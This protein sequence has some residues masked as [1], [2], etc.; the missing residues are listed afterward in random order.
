ML[1]QIPFNKPFIAGKELYYIAQAVTLNNLA[2]DGHF[3]QQCC[4]LLEQTFGIHRVLLTPSCTAA[5]EM[6]AILCDL[7]PGD[8]VILPSFTFVSTASAFV[9]EGARPVFVDIRPDTLNIDENRIEEAVTD[10][11]RAIVPVHYAGIGCEMDRI[12]AIAR[13]HGLLVVE[14]A[15]QGVNSFYAGKAL[16]SI[17]D[18]GAYSF[19]ETKNYIAGE[20]GALCINRPDL[21]E[22]AE[23]I[24]DKGTNRQKFFRGLV[25]KYT[26]VDVGSSYVPSEI[27]GA[28]LYGQLEMMGP[29]SDRRREIYQFYRRH[30]KPLE[31]EGLLQL[32]YTPED[33]AANYHMFYVL[34]KDGPT[35]N[36][37]MDHL[38]QHG[39]G[40]VFH[41]V[42]L[43]SSPMGRRLGG[44][45]RELPVTDSASARL[46]R[47]PFYYTITE[48]E[49]AEVVRQIAAYFG[50]ATAKTGSE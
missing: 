45:T 13:K 4:R 29:I 14:D 35:R 17:G 43:H 42:P 6:A 50:C 24:R 41:Y 40:A 30:L 25:D 9:R 2:G 26:W 5:L 47:L 19:H 46:V 38:H 36:A 23:I 39:I 33:C 27:V 48:E 1:H 10:R 22:R 3:T 16:G 21:V 18:L 34:V 37:L 7:K 12:L 11:T 32:P 28:F 20:G 49:Q 8:E 15:A 31:S 44:D